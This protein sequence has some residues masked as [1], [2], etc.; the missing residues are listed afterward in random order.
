M[1]F[2]DSRNINRP[3]LL[4]G[5]ITF[6]KRKKKAISNFTLFISLLFQ[7]RFVAVTS[8]AFIYHC[9]P[10]VINKIITVPTRLM[11]P[12]RRKLRI[13][14]FSPL[15]EKTARKIKNMT[16]P[17]E[18]KTNIT[19]TNARNLKWLYVHFLWH[20]NQQPSMRPCTRFLSIWF[21]AANIRP[22]AGVI[23][24]QLNFWVLDLV[25]RR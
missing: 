18:K 7:I 1:S 17:T 14:V 12:C 21:H 19:P 3:G 9:P 15:L 25:G 8:N 23:E 2:D 22:I 5:F 4:P 6:A 24:Y 16:S 13:P 20:Q 11:W 10:V